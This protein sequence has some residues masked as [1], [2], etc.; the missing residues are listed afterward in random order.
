[1]NFANLTSGDTVFLDANVFVYDFGA[2]PVLGPPCKALLNRIETGDLTGFISAPVFND[3]AHRL[4][5]LDA[6]QS[7]GWAYAGIGQRL[8]RHPAEIRNLL[9]S[10][11][12]LD[13]IVRIGVRILPVK[14]QDVL[15]AADHCRNQG[16][17]S[18][19]GLIL[20]VMQSHGL[21]RLAS[22]DADFDRVPGIT[23]Y[24][25]L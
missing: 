23:R 20:A 6:C 24:S 16:V 7:L 10:R 19:D 9:K 12:A 2:D 1:M 25:P 11:Q 5:T 4:M 18:G 21:T 14:G 3:I 17:L 8:R 22:N 15:L 13:E